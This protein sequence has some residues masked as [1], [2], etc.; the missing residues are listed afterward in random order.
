MLAVAQ[1]GL[2]ACLSSVND[3]T[4]PELPEDGAILSF[5][6]RVDYYDVNYD[7]ANDRGLMY[8]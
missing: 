7:V 8:H 2:P 6:C 3:V 4:P 5:V 1:F